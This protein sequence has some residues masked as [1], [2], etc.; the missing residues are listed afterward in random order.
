MSGCLISKLNIVD[1]AGSERVKITKAE[2]TRLTESKNIN[3]SLSH[4]SKI[5]NT[6]S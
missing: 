1:L 5:I 2:G 3:K 6:L 4:L